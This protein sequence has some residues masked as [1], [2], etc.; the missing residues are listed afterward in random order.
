MGNLHWRTVNRRGRRRIVVTKELPGER[1]LRLLAQADCRVD[2]CASDARLTRD[3]ILGMLANGCAGAIGQLTE[4]W[5]EPELTA[6]QASGGLVYSTYAVGF[7]NV[8]VA[9]ATRLGLPVGNTPG[10][11]TEATAELAVALTL[12]AARR[13]TEGDSFARGGRFVGWLPTLLLGTLLRRK[14]LGIIGAG[15][16]GATYARIMLTGYHMNVLYYD[17][18]ANGDLERFAAD[19]SGLLEAREEE[20][21]VCRRASSLEELLRAADVISL[22]ATL[23]HGTRRLIGAAQLAL[24]KPD[25]I[26][27]NSSRG[28]LHDEAALAAHCRDNPSFRAALDV[29]E[30][31]P[32][33]DPGLVTLPNVVMAPHLGSATDETR[34]GMATLAA[35]NVVAILNDW[36]VWGAPDMRP[37]LSDP[38]PEAAPSIVNAAEL[39][40]RR[41][42]GTS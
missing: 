9:S 19:Y 23:D 36:P 28:A 38:A 4:R 11:L 37:F 10:V 12:A 21:L 26:L 8:D 29:Y 33:V 27:V 7:D 40:L 24:M 15:R 31:E 41:Y 32:A 6:L 34:A 18:R 14:T 22:H 25:A 20:G 5:D 13:I 3:D 30:H 17:P 42:G 39:G 16:I 2:I 35:A 1:W